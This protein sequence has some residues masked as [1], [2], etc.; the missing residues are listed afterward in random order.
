MIL[1]KRITF[2]LSLISITICLNDIWETVHAPDILDIGVG[3]FEP[4]KHWMLDFD[5]FKP[6]SSALITAKFP[7]YI[8]HFAFFCLVGTIL[9]NCIRLFKR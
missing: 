4:F 2:W 1:L 9:D 8:V 7:G 6:P 5:P 3:P